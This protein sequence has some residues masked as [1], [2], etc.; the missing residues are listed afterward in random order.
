MTDAEPAHDG[1]DPTPIQVDLP[2]Q[3]TYLTL[4]RPVTAKT[5]DGQ[6]VTLQPGTQCI[7]EGRVDE[8]RI[9]VK[10]PLFARGV[11]TQADFQARP[12]VDDPDGEEEGR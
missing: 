11:L 4:S 5:T 9:E 10:A 3:G 8:Y 1:M 6:E 7:A 12:V 2:P